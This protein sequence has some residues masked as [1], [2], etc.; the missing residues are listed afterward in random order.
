VPYFVV[1]YMLTVM[2]NLTSRTLIP[3]APVKTVKL[4]V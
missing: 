4:V 2:R 1:V 3:I